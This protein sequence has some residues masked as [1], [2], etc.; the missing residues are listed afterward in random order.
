VSG[1]SLIEAQARQI[2]EELS[3]A[4]DRAVYEAAGRNPCE[5]VLFAGSLDA[6]LAV[7]GRDLGRDEVRAGQP[8]IGAAGQR[9]RLALGSATARS[10]EPL[11]DP[12]RNALFTN[13]VPYKPIA[14]KAWSRNIRERFRP[15]LAALLSDAWQGHRVIA[16]GAEASEWFLP[17]AQEAGLAPGEAKYRT[18]IHC[19]LPRAQGTKQIEVAPMPHPSPLNQ[20]WYEA[21][22]SLMGARL[23]AW[24]LSHKAPAE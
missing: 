23:D 15:V 20:R 6:A 17:Y 11:L 12:P 9:V 7:V 13:L 1:V 5:P 16:L 8:L 22:P 14:N 10:R 24:G 18:V 19:A 21:F 3:L 4:V 2:A